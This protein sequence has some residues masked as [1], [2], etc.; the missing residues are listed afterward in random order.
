MKADPGRAINFVHFIFSHQLK[1]IAYSAVPI[2]IFII[3][4]FDIANK[5]E[6]YIGVFASVFSFA[7]YLSFVIPGMNFHSRYQMSIF[8][9]IVIISMYGL[10]LIL[11]DLTDT[12]KYY[13]LMVFSVVCTILVLHNIGRFTDI[14]NESQNLHTGKSQRVELAKELQS[15]DG[16]VLAGSQAGRLPYFSRVTHIDILGLNTK[17]VAYN[18]Y[19]SPNFRKELA[20]YIYNDKI[21]DIYMGYTKGSFNDIRKYDK[22]GIYRE[23]KYEEMDVMVLKNSDNYSKII[24]AFESTR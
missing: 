18:R 2:L 22:Q 6:F 11:E 12:S 23:I 10:K 17:F 1:F 13:S 15:I 7:I 8:I 9:P 3:S 4:L 16:L 19:S 5:K 21:P 20:N 24:K 14:R